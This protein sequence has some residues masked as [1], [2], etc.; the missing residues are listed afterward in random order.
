MSE[1]TYTSKIERV[2][3][4][5]N[6]VYGVLSQP[7]KLQPLVAAVPDNEYIDGIELDHDTIKLKTKQF[8]NVVMRI[9]EREENKTVKFA[10]DNSPIHVNLWIQFKPTQADQT[11]VRL[12][13]RAD[14]PMMVK[15]MFGS[16]I[17]EALNKVASA[18]PMLP[19]QSLA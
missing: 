4:A 15:M 11:A 9:V 12:T 18:L 8:G 3:H 16:K 13:L 14:I 6:V 17:E 1:T 19:Y 5:D 7:N 10:S 2:N